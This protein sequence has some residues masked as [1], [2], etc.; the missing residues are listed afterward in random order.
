M[1]VEG[2][3]GFDMRFAKDGLHGIGN[4]FAIN[5]KYSC[6]ANYVHTEKDGSKGVFFATVLV[7]ESADH[8]DSNHKMPPL[9]PG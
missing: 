8:V 2:E 3:V 4:Y 5:A 1:I 7:G 6:G 9:K